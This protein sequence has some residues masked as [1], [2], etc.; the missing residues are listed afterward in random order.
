MKEDRAGREQ[1]V[2][3]VVP[4]LRAENCWK[5]RSARWLEDG[6]LE[7]ILEMVVQSLLM[8]KPWYDCG[9]GDGRG[10]WLREWVEGRAVESEPEKEARE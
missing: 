3:L 2:G 5:G 9:T 1:V 6:S 7:Q 4:S 8:A 10:E